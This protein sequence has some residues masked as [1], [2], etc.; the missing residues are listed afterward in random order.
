MSE[1]LPPEGEACLVWL[2]GVEYPHVAKWNGCWGQP[3]TGYVLWGNVIVWVPLSDA[4]HATR[5]REALATL[6]LRGCEGRD[7]DGCDC[8]TCIARKALEEP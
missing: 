6:T 5:W 7:R 4:R 3:T 1:K 8:P 2:D